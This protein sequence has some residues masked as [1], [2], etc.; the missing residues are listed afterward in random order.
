MFDINSGELRDYVQFMI[1]SDE[2]DEWGD[3]QGSTMVFDARA[4]VQV[5]SGR[6]N[7]DYG[8]VVTQEVITVKMYYDSRA[9]N[10]QNILWEGKEYEV[11]HVQPDVR[12]RA[13]I[14]TAESIKR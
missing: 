1:D 8:T 4:N 14:V 3:P 5:K 10:D 2:P 6:Q 7:A 12:K 11:Q 9:A 13:M